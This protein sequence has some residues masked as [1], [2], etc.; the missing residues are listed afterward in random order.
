ML[1]AIGFSREEPKIRFRGLWPGVAVVYTITAALLG[2]VALAAVATG[3]AVADFTREPVSALQE[4][5]CTGGACS[6]IGLVSN[7]GLLVWAAA[8]GVCL[9]TAVVCR[10]DA[11]SSLAGPFLWLGLLTAVLA[12]DDGFQ[13][14][15]Y[16]APAVVAQGE[17]LT[18][19][20]YAL[21]LG[22]ILL[23]Y[24]SFV[25]RTPF[26]LLLASGALFAVSIAC[27]R[28]ATDLHLVEDGAKL[29][30]IVSWAMWLV[31]TSVAVLR[32]DTRAP[33][34]SA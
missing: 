34:S 30:G 33:A 25:L 11:R 26:G 31:S 7:A 12:V 32:A 21:A 13:L 22:V 16:A 28:W 19:L 8:A 3:R 23:R 1:E 10:L 15:E 5:T 9:V 20:V 17:A 29:L 24:R 2:G 27:D 4:T 14:H 6:Y 18:I